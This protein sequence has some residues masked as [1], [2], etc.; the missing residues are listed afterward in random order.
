MPK[1]K[2]AARKQFATALDAEEQGWLATI[3]KRDGLTQGA[4]LRKAFRRLARAEGLAV[5]ESP[6]PPENGQPGAAID[7]IRMGLEVA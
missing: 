4:V 5:D 3:A 1:H 2:P 6:T 7:K